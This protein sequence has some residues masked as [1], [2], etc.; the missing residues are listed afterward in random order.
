[1]VVPILRGNDC[2]LRR[3]LAGE[4]QSSIYVRHG[5]AGKDKRL[6]DPAQL[7]KRSGHIGDAGRCFARWNAG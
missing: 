7:S 2:F 1:V 3:R 5:W 6:I 4:D